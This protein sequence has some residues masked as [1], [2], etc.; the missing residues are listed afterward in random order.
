MIT[1]QG[2]PKSID[3]LIHEVDF[4][5]TKGG[6]MHVDLYAV[7][8]GKEITTDVQ[9]E[10]V[11]ESPVE[12][13]GGMVSKILHE[14]EVTCMPSVLPAHIEVDISSLT[15]V[16]EKIHVSD[17]VVPKGV[18]IEN[19]PTDVVALAVAGGASEEAEEAEAAEATPA[20]A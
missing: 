13:V 11:G 17:L 18:V 6:I 15:A 16:D 2:L 5:P 9:L 1:L 19:E 4:N 12:K 20:A 3:V 14:V 8:A 10:F 7:E